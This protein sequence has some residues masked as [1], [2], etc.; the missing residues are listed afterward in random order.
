[1]ARTDFNL[2]AV[3]EHMRLSEVLTKSEF[4]DFSQEK[5]QIIAVQRPER[6]ESPQDVVEKNL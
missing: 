2:N 6:S 1:M 4:G 5:S 3:W